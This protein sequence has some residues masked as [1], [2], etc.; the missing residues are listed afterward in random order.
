MLCAVALA[1]KFACRQVRGA[2]GFAPGLDRELR[3]MRGALRTAFVPE[4]DPGGVQE[5]DCDQHARNKFSERHAAK[6]SAGKAHRSLRRVYLSRRYEYVT[7]GRR[8]MDPVISEYASNA[9][10]YDRKWSFYV[11]S[12]TRET[13]ARLPMNP[14]DRV[15]D[16]GCGTGELLSRLA[17]KYPQARLAGLD[18]VPEMLA[19]ARDKLSDAADLRVGRANELP[20]E[21]GSFDLVVSCNMFGSSATRS[22]GCGA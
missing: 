8:I 3:L 6:Y 11:E 5:E 22:A 18:P 13:I 20:W 15:L 19:V 2:V 7:T 10:T 14:A 21:D 17:A 16:V 1:M 4:R 12:T 9:R